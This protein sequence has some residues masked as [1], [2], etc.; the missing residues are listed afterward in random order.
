[1]GLHVWDHQET[2]H[3]DQLP[4]HV[5]PPSSATLAVCTIKAIIDQATFDF[6]SGHLPAPSFREASPP[7]ENLQKTAR[8]L[9]LSSAPSGT[10]P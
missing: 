5:G 7:I 4:V 3:K 1:M 2:F 10:A 6:V 9:K 8:T